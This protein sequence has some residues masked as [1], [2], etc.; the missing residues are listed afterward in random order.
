MSKVLCR[1][2]YSNSH[3]E[4]GVVK[5]KAPNYPYAAQRPHSK[6]SKIMF[7]HE[8]LQMGQKMDSCKLGKL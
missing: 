1:P 5:G 7:A 8:G 3:L 2:Y 4:I 6:K